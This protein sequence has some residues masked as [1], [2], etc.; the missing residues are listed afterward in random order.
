MPSPPRPTTRALTEPVTP[1]AAAVEL[2]AT[3]AVE[4]PKV[5]VA[6]RGPAPLSAGSFDLA[7]AAQVLGG[8]KTSR[9]HR[10][11]VMRDRL[12]TDVGAYYLPQVLGGELQIHAIARAGVDPAALRAAIDDELATLLKTPVPADELGRAKTVLRAELLTGL[13]DLAGRAEALATW[14]ALTG[15]PDYAGR[16]LAQLAAVTAD[17][18]RVTAGQ[19][20]A[21]TATVTMTIVPAPAAA[22]ETIDPAPTAPKGATP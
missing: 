6:A 22:E 4:V 8:G 16:E 5:V 10:R 9:L 7:V 11:L 17:S 20:L 12:A 1:L 14:A 19:F 18:V 3:D 13:E 21:P 15:T 2:T